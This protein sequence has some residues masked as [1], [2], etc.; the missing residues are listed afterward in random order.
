LAIEY[1]ERDIMRWLITNG[2][3][4]NAESTRDEDGFGGHTPLF[5]TTVTFTYEDTSKAAY[6]L[7][8]GANPNHRCSIRKQLKYTGKRHMADV[9]EYRDV[10]PITLAEQWQSPG[11]QTISYKTIELLKKSGGIYGAS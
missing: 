7:E 9:K 5:H 8:K 11:G 1:D 2:A 6:L 3:E 10:T 4:V